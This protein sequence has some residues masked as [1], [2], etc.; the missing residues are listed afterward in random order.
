MTRTETA[1]DKGAGYIRV[2]NTKSALTLNLYFDSS[3][4]AGCGTAENPFAATG[5]S[6][7][8]FYLNDFE[9]GLFNTPGVTASTGFAAIC[10]SVDGDDSVIDGKGSPTVGD[11]Y[12]FQP[13]F[14]GILFTFDAGTLGALPTS[15]SL[16][17]TDGVGTISFDAFGSG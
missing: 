9:D 5:F 6:G 4:I 13:R 3:V 10:D 15:A 17:W 1:E 14:Y 8:Y 7:G 2:L 16:V 11:S 12:F